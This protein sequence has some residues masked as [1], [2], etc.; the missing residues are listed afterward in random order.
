MCLQEHKHKGVISQSCQVTSVLTH[1][2]THTHD[3][4]YPEKGPLLLYETIP[5]LLDKIPGKQVASEAAGNRADDQGQLLGLEDAA[6]QTCLQDPG[7]H[8]GISRYCVSV[9]FLFQQVNNI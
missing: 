6:L 9:F 5:V 8:H 1:S 2:H 3:P 7:H 4:S